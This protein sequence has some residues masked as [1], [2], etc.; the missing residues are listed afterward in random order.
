MTHTE[1]KED[2]K[3]HWADYLVFSLSLL[4]SLLVGVF[5]FVK[6]M[7]KDER[8]KEMLLG[9]QQ[10]PFVPVALSIMASILNG[11]F[12][13]GVPAEI[14]YF[15]PVYS[16]IGVSFLTVGIFVALVFLPI[17]RR[18]QMTSAY[19]VRSGR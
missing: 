5:F 16:L 17:F 19:E 12:I 1:D 11:V 13:I 6:D 15:G 3:F 10:L 8:T 4:V 9:G 14:Y 2:F 18:L 7:A